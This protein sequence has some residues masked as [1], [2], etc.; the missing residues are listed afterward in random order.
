MLRVQL[1]YQLLMTLPFALAGLAYGWR[2]G[3]RREARTALILVAAMILFGA[4][5]ADRVGAWVNWLGSGLAHLT[6]QL[7]GTAPFDGRFVT[8]V[9]QGVLLLIGFL[10]AVFVAYWAGG[11]AGMRRG[12][13]GLRYGVLGAGIGLVNAL[14]VASYVLSYFGQHIPSSFET[15]YGGIVPSGLSNGVF[16]DYLPAILTLAAIALLIVVFLR[17]PKIR[18]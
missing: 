10:L 2:R 11:P 17:L 4:R 6:E 9:N 14:L 3:W 7:L 13:R 8:P 18:G 16:G 15:E 1:S 12:G 5:Y